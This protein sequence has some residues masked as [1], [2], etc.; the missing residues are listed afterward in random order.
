[1]DRYQVLW[2]DPWG[3]QQVTTYPTRRAAG[4]AAAHLRTTTRK[5]VQVWDSQQN[6]LSGLL[7]L[8]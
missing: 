5:P 7:R 1:M 2:L 6:P 3:K 4:A 8:R